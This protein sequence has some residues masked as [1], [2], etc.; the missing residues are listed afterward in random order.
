MEGD[1]DSGVCTFGIG[2]GSPT[3]QDVARLA[4]VSV[5]S[6]SSVLNGRDNVAPEIREAVT[7]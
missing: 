4:K 5:G 2:I 1:A 7:W 3:V 6:V